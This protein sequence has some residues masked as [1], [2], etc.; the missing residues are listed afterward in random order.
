ML[1]NNESLLICLQGAVCDQDPQFEADKYKY[2][3][4]ANTN[5]NYLVNGKEFVE[6][7]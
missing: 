7:Q 3:Y 2:E 5:I 4:G 1:R 6:E